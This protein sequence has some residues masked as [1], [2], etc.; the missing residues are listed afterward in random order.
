MTATPAPRSQGNGVG[1]AKWGIGPQQWRDF[2]TGTRAI[3][4]LIPGSA[5]FGLAFGALIS[6]SGISAWTG[7][8]ASVSVVAGASQIAIV[9]QVRVGAPAVI[10][11]MTALVIN[12]RFALYS[13]AL[14]PVYSAFPLRWRLGL[15]HLMTDQAAVVS[16][17]HAPMWPDP[18]RRRWFFLGVS[19]IFVAVWIMGTAAGIA[20]GP[21]IPDAWQIGFIVPLMFIAVMVPALRSWPA[22]TAAAV[23]VAVVVLLKD[24]PYGL[25]VLLGALAGIALGSFVPSRDVPDVGEAEQEATP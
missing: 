5:A 22:L 16:V 25:N 13:A 21:V 10:A 12:A 18:V 14:A 11:I 2:W 20:L 19:L 17:L 24:L 23:A 7:N 9:E 6:V 15:A 3:L 4:P 1:R 8:F